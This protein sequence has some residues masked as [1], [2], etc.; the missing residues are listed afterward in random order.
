MKIAALLGHGMQRKLIISFLLL[1][2]VPMSIM[3]IFS[4]SKSS[5]ILVDQAN[6]QMR[7]MAY[8]IEQL[9]LSTYK[10]QWKDLCPLK[11][12]IDEIAVGIKIPGGDGFVAQF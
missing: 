8:G 11:M 9:T 5:K 10:M 7:N 3:G 1:G 4:Y 12:A 6:V 2:T